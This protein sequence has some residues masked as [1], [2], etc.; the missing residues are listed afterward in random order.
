MEFTTL[1]KRLNESLDQERL[2][3]VL[4]GYFGLL[5]LVLAAT[6]GRRYGEPATPPIL[7]RR[8]PFPVDRIEELQRESIVGANDHVML[9]LLEDM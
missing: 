9:A 7:L 3:A 1:S 6:T 4:S 5:A 8:A 2:L